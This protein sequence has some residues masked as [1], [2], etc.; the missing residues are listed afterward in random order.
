M[1]NISLKAMPRPVRRKRSSN[2][3]TVSFADVLDRCGA[4][5]VGPA[6]Q[7]LAEVAGEDHVGDLV[8]QHGIEDPL[9]RTL[10]RHPPARHLAILKLKRGAPPAPSC[11]PAW[12]VITQGCDQSGMVLPTRPRP[13]RGGMVGRLRDHAGEV[14][15]RRFNDII[16]ACCWSLMATSSKQ[17]KAAIRP[18]GARHDTGVRSAWLGCRARL[19]QRAH[20][21][22]TRRERLKAARNAARPL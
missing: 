12:T 11:G 21:R 10:N 7:R 8:R 16:G 15:I 1:A 6:R 2:S 19:R 3:V 20:R 4:A 17:P 9:L 14:G 13:A 18:T 5:L 22:A